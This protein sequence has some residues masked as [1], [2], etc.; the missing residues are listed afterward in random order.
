MN[1]LG[2]IKNHGE[3]E[4]SNTTEDARGSGDDQQK[5]LRKKVLNTCNQMEQ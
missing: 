5:G 3:R 4:R 2:S 1:Q